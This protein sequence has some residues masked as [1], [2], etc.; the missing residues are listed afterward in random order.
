MSHFPIWR[1]LV[2]FSTKK[3]NLDLK[4]GGDIPLLDLYVLS[5]VILK[6]INFMLCRSP[7]SE[8]LSACIFKHVK[9]YYFFSCE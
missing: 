6:I 3:T 7:Q 8:L 4:F 5:K 9:H 1:F 2:L